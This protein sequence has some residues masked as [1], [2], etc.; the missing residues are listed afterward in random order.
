VEDGVQLVDRS[1]WRSI[2]NCGSVADSF[3]VGGMH[4]EVLRYAENFGFV[5]LS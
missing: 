5:N 2:K 1:W 4:I 3:K